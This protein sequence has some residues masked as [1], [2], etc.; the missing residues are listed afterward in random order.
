MGEQAPA[1]LAWQRFF[2]WAVGTA[3][4]VAAFIYAFVVTVDPWDVLPLSPPFHR[5][6][7]STNARFAFPALAS[8]PAFDSAVF[9]TSTARLLRP[10]G[11]L[12]VVDFAR[13]TLESLRS[14]HA[15]RR[16]GFTDEEVAG[17]CR[18]AGLGCGPVIHLP[19]DPLT[20]TVWPATRLAAVGSPPTILV[21]RS[22]VS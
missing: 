18:T 14:D 7:V 8:N 12:L 21:S 11:R 22:G 1:G 10:G 4:G 15:H 17:W 6:P 2:R 16:L 19:G 3:L 5:G 20:V 9:G 13:H